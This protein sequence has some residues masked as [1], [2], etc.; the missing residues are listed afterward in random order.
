MVR[1]CSQVFLRGKHE[2]TVEAMNFHLWAHIVFVESSRIHIS[3]SQLSIHFRCCSYFIW[4]DKKAEWFVVHIFCE[5][6]LLFA[7]LSIAVLLR[8][9]FLNP[10]YSEV[11]HGMSERGLWYS[12]AHFIFS[13]NLCLSF[14][15]MTRTLRKQNTLMINLNTKWHI[16]RPVESTSVQREHQLPLKMNAGGN[17]G[18]DVSSPTRL[19]S[20][21]W[22]MVNF[23]IPFLVQIN[24]NDSSP[25][26]CH[27]FLLVVV[28][29]YQDLPRL[30]QG[31]SCKHPWPGNLSE[32]MNC[33]KGIFNHAITIMIW[34]Q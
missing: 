30:G 17:W 22:K 16:A 8:L 25:R 12:Y 1:N 15:D 34:C 6:P 5:E 3:T 10:L 32:V 4:K 11:W 2:L 9:C 31:I 27:Q 14:F 20:P 21:G 29:C 26:G 28:I 24:S 7:L 13:L 23:L 19:S 33:R 18:K